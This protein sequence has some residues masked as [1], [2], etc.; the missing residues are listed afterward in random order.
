[1]PGIRSRFGNTEGL[2]GKLTILLSSDDS[3]TLRNYAETLAQG[4]RGLPILFDVQS[5]AALARPELLVEPY[6]ERAA[7]LGVTVSSIARTVQLSTIGDLE[8][9]LAKFDLPGRQIG[10][11]VQLAPENRAQLETLSQVKVPTN[12]GKGVQLRNVAEIQYGYGPSQIDRYDRRRRVS[13]E[14]NLSEGVALGDALAA[15]KALQAYKDMPESVEELPAGDVEIQQD[16]F[17]GFFFAI[18]AAVLLIYAVLV[19]LYNDFFHP[20]TI[21]LSLPLSIGGALIALVVCQE[22][23]GLYA[24]IGIVMLMGLAIKNS[25]L[26]VDYCLMA[27]AEG[28]PREEA[29]LESGEARMRPILMTTVAMIAGMLPIALGVGAGAEI[30]QAMAIAVIGGLITSTFLTLLVVPVVHTYIDDLERFVMTYG[31]GWL[32]RHREDEETP[33]GPT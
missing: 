26:L 19:L 23:L 24:L 9:N 32:K 22:P 17:A 10:I 12:D 14:A 31:L 6:P 15:V 16:V 29:V 18:G 2:S 3:E 20:F 11:R 27:E 5:S 8:Q 33:Q 28:T 4:M 21:M 25:I 30:R 7:E 1:M 13:I